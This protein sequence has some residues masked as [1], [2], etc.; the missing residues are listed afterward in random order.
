MESTLKNQVTYKGRVPVIIISLAALLCIGFGYLLQLL[1]PIIKVFV[2]ENYFGGIHVDTLIRILI[3]FALNTVSCLILI[4]YS[5][6]TYKKVKPRFFLFG[7]YALLTLQPTIMIMEKFFGNGFYFGIISTIFSVLQ[8]IGQILVLI[9]FLFAAIIMIVGGN[10]KVVLIIVS[11]IALSVGLIFQLFMVLYNIVDSIFFINYYIASF[12]SNTV[13]IINEIIYFILN[14]IPII[15]SCLFYIALF[16]FTLTYKRKVVKL[17]ID[18]ENT[19]T[20]Q[21]L[22][23]LNENLDN[24]TITEDEYNQQREMIIGK[25]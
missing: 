1:F 20:E 7:I 24:G 16:I 25:L 13:F 23:I 14:L 11:I 10:N 3:Y 2:W 19:T 9:A 22:E 17:S 6:N 18:I 15:G 5:M 8:V 12:S 4:I 21:A